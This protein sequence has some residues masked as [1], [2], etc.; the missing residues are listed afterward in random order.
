MQSITVSVIIARPVE[1]VFSYY[2]DPANRPQWSDHVL[3]GDWI[4]YKTSEVDAVFQVTIKQW[5]RVIRTER[6]ITEYEPNKKM[7]YVLDSNFIQ[8]YS[9]QTFE[10]HPIG[11]KFTIQAKMKPKGWLRLIYRFVA[12]GQADH[13]D[14]EANNLKRA[15]EKNEN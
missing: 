11:T 4:S 9:C 1:E 10:P 15:L 5:G 14:E 8:V 7:C 13:L 2:I 12:K 3:S 6:K